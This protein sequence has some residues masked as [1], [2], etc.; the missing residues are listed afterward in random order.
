MRPIYLDF[1]ATTPLLPQVLE[2]MLPYLKEHFGNPSSGHAYGQQA[3]EAVDRARAQVANLLGCRAEEIVFTSGGTEANNLALFGAVEAAGIQRVITSSVE[4]PAVE[5]P[6]R[7]LEKRGIEVTRVAVDGRGI[8]DPQ[9]ISRALAKGGGRALVSVMHANPITL[10]D[11]DGVEHD[12]ELLELLNVGKKSFALMQPAKAK[13]NE[14]ALFRF[15][16]DQEGNPESFM[17]PTEKELE[18]AAEALGIEV[19][20]DCGDDCCGG[21]DCEQPA[22]KKK[23]QSKKKPAAK[24]SSSRKTPAK[25]PA[26]KAARS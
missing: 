1:N 10:T 2:A 9:A 20:D 25:K 7:A 23:A 26:R 8:V 21:C 4:H 15:T 12:F 24:A 13:K 6:C 16:T 18:Q 11:E 17:P 22:E 5:Q 3:K 19:D 14:V